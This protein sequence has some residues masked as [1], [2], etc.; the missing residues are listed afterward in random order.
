ML[1]TTAEQESVAYPM[2][3]VSAVGSTIVPGTMTGYWT[4]AEMQLYITTEVPTVKPSN[5]YAVEAVWDKCPMTTLHC[6]A[7]SYDNG[8]RLSWK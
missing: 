2:W 1:S 3:P 5:H 4:T 8:W 7:F 6:V